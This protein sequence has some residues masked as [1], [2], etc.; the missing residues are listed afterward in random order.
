MFSPSR[1][2]Y[3]LAVH[4]ALSLLPPSLTGQSMTH[5]SA[6]QYEPSFCRSMLSSA[7]FCRASRRSNASRIRPSMGLRRSSAA[8]TSSTPAQQVTPLATAS[9]P[10]HCTQHVCL[11]KQSKSCALWPKTFNSCSKLCPCT[12]VR[13]ASCSVPSCLLNRVRWSLLE[14]ADC[15]GPSPDIIPLGGLL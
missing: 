8:I 4:R 7:M 11:P 2:S 10:M 5:D 15:R 6:Y 1:I 9:N 12:S 13:A 3:L 14:F